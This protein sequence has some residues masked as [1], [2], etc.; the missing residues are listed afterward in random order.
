MIKRENLEKIE[1]IKNLCLMNSKKFIQAA[2]KIIE[3][4]NIQYHLAT[5]A[6]EEIG[7]I[8]IYKSR[9]IN[10]EFER[11]NGEV[12]D[13][14]DD[15]LRKLFIAFWHPLPVKSIYRKES[16]ESTKNLAK[17]V[18][19]KR[20]DALYVNPILENIPYES[21]TLKE[22]KDLIEL[23]ESIINIEE[24]YVINESTEIEEELQWFVSITNDKYQRKWIFSKTSLDTLDEFADIKKWIKWLYEK[25]TENEKELKIIA[26]RELSLNEI[27][28]NE[29]KIPKWKV[30]VRMYTYSH[31][32][33]QKALNEWGKNFDNFKFFSTK[34][35]NEF[36]V[37]ILMPKSILI[38]DVYG[39]AY[40]L[41]KIFLLSLNIGSLGFFW[42]YLPKIN[43]KFYEE[44]WDVENNAGIVIESDEIN[45]INFD[46]AVLN[47]ENIK[48]QS[49]VFIYIIDILQTHKS[50]FINHYISALIFLSK[51]D[52]FTRYEN[53][54][55]QQFYEAIKAI[56][57]DSGDWDG[58]SEL[59][60]SY[61]NKLNAKEEIITELKIFLDYAKTLE[62]GGVKEP[63]HIEDVY[64][65][66][67]LI[68][69]Y[70]ITKA[71]DNLKSKNDMVK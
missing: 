13:N 58:K 51:N 22:A 64:K 61:Q 8:Q 70:I 40:N 31:S 12:D 56:F 67:T 53:H 57:F 46:K 18:H 71:Y 45:K 44:I 6:I 24:A 36:I 29:V 35:K 7:K 32:I 14:I 15:H 54:A 19:N 33:R 17:K 2:K 50:R 66:K 21:I 11:D 23:A 20:L 41:V 34:K 28:L 26:T 65:F 38:K 48:N 37:E 30:K 60:I 47:E 9:I 27:P 1:K 43:S 63:V 59:Y 69:L 49:M 3:H 5:L 62:K 52:L 42:F 16:I 25:H 39:Q 55:F 4:P 10:S 68:D